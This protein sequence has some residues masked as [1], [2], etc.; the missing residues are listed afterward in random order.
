ML[1][2]EIINKHPE[3]KE[4]L[5]CQ[6]KTLNYGELR[7]KILLWAAHLQNNGVK[8]GDKVG[9]FSKN[10]NEF[11]VAYFAIIKAGA[12]VVPLNFQLAMPEVAYI[13][14]DTAMKVIVTRE[15]INL[16]TALKERN[17]EDIMQLD[18]VDLELPTTHIYGQ[19][20]M[21]EDDNCTIIYTSGTTGTP[22]GAML[23][24]KNLVSNASDF[25]ERVLMYAEDKILCVLPMYHCFAWTVSVVG[26]LLHGGCIIVQEQYTLQETLRLVHKH[27]I[28]Q[29]T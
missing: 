19:P 21:C 14:Q 23:S 3:N 17:C 18:F 12:V 4:A 25:T 16:S 11:I 8:K 9:L 15:K 10:C 13:V 2:F 24:H 26:P 7:E 1:F 27:Q 29:F 20:E 6:D 5:I 22:K 28:N